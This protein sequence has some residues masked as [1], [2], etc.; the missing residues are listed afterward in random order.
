[1]SKNEKQT[2]NDKISN[3]IF[4]SNDCDLSDNEIEPYINRCVICNEYLGPLNPRQYCCKT[5]CPYEG[6]TQEEIKEIRTPEKRTKPKNIP[7]KRK[8]KGISLM[9]KFDKLQKIE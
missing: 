2:S 6:L 8:R 3:E 7:P 9:S 4:E 1:M 5:Y